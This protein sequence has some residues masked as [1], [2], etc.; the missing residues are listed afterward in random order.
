MCLA[1]LIFDVHPLYTLLVASNRDEFLHRPTQAA[2]FWSDSPDILAGRDGVQG[3][4]WFGMS[5]SGRVALI[6]NYREI[7]QIPN[8][9]SR[10]KLTR[11]FLEGT[12]S[13]LEYLIA[14]HGAAE[15]YNGYNLLVADAASKTLAYLTNRGPDSQTGPRLLPPGIYA[16]SNA[17]LDSPWPK[18]EKGKETL[19]LM[20]EASNGQALDSQ[21]ILAEVLTD[22]TP[23]RD[24]NLPITGF[25]AERERKLSTAFVDTTL[26]GAKYGTSTQTV[27]TIFRD[28]RVEW[29]EHFL[30]TQDTKAEPG[31][32]D[33][34]I[35]L[36]IKPREQSEDRSDCSNS[37]H[38]GDASV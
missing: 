26:E 9:P 19:R 8:A 18:A 4:T 13:P 11:N 27:A 35:H 29:L 28:G 14:V 2:H 1:F 36:Q 3:G 6:T 15:Q 25:P 30:D 10:G 37:A 21:K 17:V 23:V 12:Q 34:L 24:E 16:V 20:L 33:Q 5:Q 7:E 31:W 32:R 38:P 22:Q